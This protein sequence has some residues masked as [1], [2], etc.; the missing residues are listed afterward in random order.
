MRVRKRNLKRP[1]YDLAV[2]W[3]ALNDEPGERDVA[4]VDSLISVVLVA[5]LWHVSPADVAR[6]VVRFRERCDEEAR[7]HAVIKARK[8]KAAA[9]EVSKPLDYEEMSVLTDEAE[10]LWAGIAPDA[11]EGMESAPTPDIIAELVLDGGRLEERLRELRD[12][13][14][15]YRVDAVRTSYLGSALAKLRQL[16]HPEQVRYLANRCEFGVL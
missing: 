12:G 4:V 5:D 11:F 8:A 2:E 1:R 6:D 16:D 13:E 9:A 14:D 3:I 10:R 7:R 15:P